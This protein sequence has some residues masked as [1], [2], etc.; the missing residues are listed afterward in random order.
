MAHFSPWPIATTMRHLASAPNCDAAR[1]TGLAPAR[2]GEP[3][4]WPSH[5]ADGDGI[6]CEPWGPRP[7]D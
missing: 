4:Y 3:G 5:D 6:A 1:A 7:R 2:Q